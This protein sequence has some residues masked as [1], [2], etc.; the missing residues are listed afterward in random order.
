M[1]KDSFSLRN[2]NGFTEDFD[3]T[4]SFTAMNGKDKWLRA[5][6]LIDMNGVTKNAAISYSLNNMNGYSI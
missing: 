4:Y 6:S 3:F 1:P 2:M 5:F